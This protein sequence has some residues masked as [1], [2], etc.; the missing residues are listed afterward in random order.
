MLSGIIAS[1]LIGRVLRTIPGDI[2]VRSYSDD[3]GICARSPAAT[4]TIRNAVTS[5]FHNLKAGPLTFKYLETAEAR[6]GFSYLNY[7]FRLEDHGDDEHVHIFPDRAAFKN[8]RARVHHLLDHYEGSF[9][10]KK[11]R[12][13]E[14]VKRWRLSQKSWTL[15]AGS[16]KLLNFSVEQMIEDHGTTAQ[17]KHAPLYQCIGSHSGNTPFSEASAG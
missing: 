13:H 10:S 9:E 14:Y 7:H 16:I 15:K 11:T 1:G 5:L 2:G 8:L 17:L 4:A 12:I 6:E 3:L